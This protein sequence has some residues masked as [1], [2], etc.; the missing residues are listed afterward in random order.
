MAEAA[1]NKSTP[2]AA[3]RRWLRG[4]VAVVLTSGPLVGGLLAPPVHAAPAQGSA[5]ASTPAAGSAAP[6]AAPA[7]TGDRKG[8]G[9]RTADITIRTLSP[10]TP[11]KDDTLNVTGT[12]TNNGRSSISD[13]QIGLRVGPA[14][15]SRGALGQ[16]AKREDYL[17]GADGDEVKAKEARTKVGSMRPGIRRTFK[18]KLPVSALKLDSSGVYQLG[19]TLTGQTRERPYDQILGIERTFLPWQTSDA[20]NKTGLT[21]LWPLISRPHMTVRMESDEEQTPVFRD[22]DLAKELAP[23]GR[24]QQMVKLGADLP[25]TWI[26][27]PDLLSTVNAMTEPYR[28]QKKGGGTRPGKGQA[29]AKQWLMD[30]QGAVKG[31][32]IATLPFGDPDL[33]SLAHRGRDVPGALSVLRNAN[34]RAVHT[35]ESVLHTKPSTDYAWPAEGAVDPSIV[36]VATS[37]GAHNVI[38]RSDSLRDTPLSYTPTSA[39]PIGGGNTALVADAGLSQAFEGDMTQPGAT[40]RAVQRFLSETHTLTAQVPNKQRDILVAPQR[41]PSTDQVRAMA[42]ALS[43][44]QKDGRWAQG[45]DLSE[46]AAAKPDPRANRKVPGSRSYPS[47]LRRQELPTEAYRQLQETDRGVN[48]FMQ[49]LT[50]DDRVETPFRS[51]TERA[52]STSWRGEPEAAKDYRDSTSDYLVGLTKKVQLIQKSPITLSGRSATIPVTVQNNLVQ[53]VDGLELR[54]KSRRRIGLDVGEAQP[55]KV[56][57]GHSQSVKFSTTSKANG[58]A[59]VEAQLYTKDGKPYGKPMVFQVNVTSITSTVLLVIA[60]GVL[61]VVL[62]GVRMYVTRKR[63]GGAPGAD[64]TGASPGAGGTEGP[65]DGDED[66][67]VP[68]DEPGGSGHGSEDGSGPEEETATAATAG[69]PEQGQDPGKPGAPGAPGE[70]DTGQGSGSASDAGEK[71][72]R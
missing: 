7:A 16:N 60:G 19:V 55:V 24:L 1:D 66:G 42:L 53:G 11:E 28:V 58:R 9:S 30:L 35:V 22:D 72:D 12:V 54:L 14:A 6:A 63:N 49:I 68:G 71:V 26:V 69:E 47:S 38:A 43:S 51:S 17:P 45:T 4:G 40:S 15:E 48:D 23:G 5:A 33:A 8:T 13:G 50:Q 67:G 20:K 27:D 41:M 64:G 2:T 32:E 10:A 36:D 59:F 39:R 25:I 31:E 61:L 62:A 52:E 70:D 44:L 46:A 3:V 57:G 18:L 56:D 37:A 29:Y 21:Y 65:G 34:E